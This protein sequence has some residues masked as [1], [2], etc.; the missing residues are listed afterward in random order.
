MKKI[1]IKQILTLEDKLVS[2][3]TIQNKAKSSSDKSIFLLNHNVNFPLPL[4]P[5][6]DIFLSKTYFFS[7]L[8]RK[9]CV[10]SYNVFDFLRD[11]VSRVPDYSHGHSDV[12][13]DDRALPKRRLERKR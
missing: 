2:R 9:H 1:I 4:F 7:A 8:F 10:Q 3:N 11:I 12:G 13:G 5:S 6:C